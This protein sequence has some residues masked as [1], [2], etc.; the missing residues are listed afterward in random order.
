MLVSADSKQLLLI[1]TI[2][3]QRTLVP[4]SGQS[5]NNVMSE[6]FQTTILVLFDVSDKAAPKA[7]SA[8]QVEGS[9][10][11]ARLVGDHAYLVVNTYPSYAYLP[12]GGRRSSP[13]VKWGGG[14]TGG[15]RVL[16]RYAPLRRA[17]AVASKLNEVPFTSVFNDCAEVR[18]S[19]H[20]ALVYGTKVLVSIDCFALWERDS[21]VGGR[22]V[23]WSCRWSRVCGNWQCASWRS[24]HFI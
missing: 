22:D 21:V 18:F 20:S 12:S 7:I 6:S 14:G 10:V 11:S 4:V 1:G 19:R 24:R 3:V 16:R 2:G 8:E 13:A 15:T 5:S 9:Y 23:R 17:S